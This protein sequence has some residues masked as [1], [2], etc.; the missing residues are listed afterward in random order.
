MWNLTLFF[1]GV[2]K[3]P[4]VSNLLPFAELKRNASQ[5][6]KL[7]VHSALDYYSTVRYSYRYVY[8]SCHARLR[9]ETDLPS[10]A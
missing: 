5:I 6:K 9:T 8:F 1:V 10:E 2:S 4:E 7:F 3:S